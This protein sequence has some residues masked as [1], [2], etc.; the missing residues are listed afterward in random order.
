MMHSPQWIVVRDPDELAVTAARRIADIA[1]AS[2]RA[3]GRFTCAL[4]GGSTP[5]A[6]YRRLASASPDCVVDWSKTFLFFGDERYVS[7][8]DDRSNYKMAHD[9]LLAEAPIPAGHVFAIPTGLPSPNDCAARYAQTLKSFFQTADNQ[10][11]T[12]DLIL[13]GL[14]DDGHVASLFPHAPSLSVRGATVTASPPGRLPPPVDRITITFDVIN[15]ACQIL[16]LVSGDNKAE[17]VRDVRSGN[18]AMADRPAMGV[19]PSHGDVTWLIDRAAGS[20]IS[21]QFT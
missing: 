15:A 3:R 1:A 14:G 8:D 16:F 19:R 9:S 18:M 20:L 7:P 12:F 11:P 5:R 6:T 4:T 13:L 10:A 17:V 21:P 2:I